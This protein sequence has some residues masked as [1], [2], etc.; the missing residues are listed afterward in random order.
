MKAQAWNKQWVQE[1]RKSETFKSSKAVWNKNP[2]RRQGNGI[3]AHKKAG[4][5]YAEEKKIMLP[6][7]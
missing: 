2:Q 3:V 6:Q 5:A 1:Y 7:W 4:E